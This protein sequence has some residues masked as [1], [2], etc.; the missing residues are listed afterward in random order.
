LVL[1]GIRN[2]SSFFIIK[3]YIMISTKNLISDLKDVP[4]EWVFENYL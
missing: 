4:R 3:N 2:G 1:R